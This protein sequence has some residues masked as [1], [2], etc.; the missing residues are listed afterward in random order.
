MASQI[1]PDPAAARHAS[2]EAPTIPGIA[3]AVT[4]KDEELF[5]LADR[6][7]RVPLEGAHGLGLF[8]HDCRYLSGYELTFAG[9]R[10]TALVGSD[11]RGYA[12]NYQLAN[13]ELRL[14]DGGVVR[15]L[16]VGVEWRRALVGA[17]RRLEE[18]LIFSNFG[19]EAVDLPIELAF[20][21]RF[22]DVFLVR[23][24]VSE[25][26][27][28]IR[29]PRWKGCELIFGYDGRDGLR[30]GLTVAFS[31]NP[32]LRS[33][34]SAAFTAELEPGTPWELIVSL[35]VT[36]GD[37]P[38][39]MLPELDPV[40]LQRVEQRV[41]RSMEAWLGAMPEIRSDS[42]LLGRV[43]HRS[44]ADVR[45]LRSRV[46]NHE[47]V[48]AGLPW[49]ATLFGRDSLITAMELLA[50]DP[51]L[52]EQ[53]L[54]LLARFQ[55]TEVDPWRDEQPGKIL[56]ELR[57]GELARLGE[58]PHT[59][60][61]GTVDATPLFLVLLARHAR[62]TGSL[63]LFHELRDAA[64]RA[65]D[66]VDGQ[67]HTD[68]QGFVEYRRLSPRGL[69]NQ[70]W[71]DSGDAIVTE[72][73]RLAAPPISLVEVQAYTYAAKLELAEVFERAGD[74]AR[75]A[76]LRA[77]ANALRLRFEQCYWL[78][79]LGSYALALEAGGRPARVI[80]SN[81]GHT[82]WCGIASPERGRRVASRLM[83]EDMFN[84][85][86]I[87]TLS[88]KERRYNPVGYHLGSVW[89]HDNA[90][91]AAGMR[92]YGCDSEA[93]AVFTGLA[94][95]AMH[96]DDY[97]LPELFA[98][99]SRAAFEIPVKYPVACHPQAWAA[100]SMPFLLAV[101]LGLVS[102]GFQ[103]ELRMVRPMLPPFVHEL[104]IHRLPVSGGS[105]SLR[106][107]RRKDGTAEVGL[108]ERAADVQVRVDDAAGMRTITG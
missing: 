74:S 107:M 56:H 25:P 98:G 101:V 93:L 13:P 43:L 91:A 6:H 41:E 60:Y 76:L 48:C 4:I 27:G 39:T 40:E 3:S 18:R 105:V 73:G 47:Y 94:H 33:A 85:W 108:I 104:E 23:N 26:G 12:A 80:A 61:Y 11:A 42:L 2:L 57:V 68:Q 69:G 44:F 83:A 31:R 32:E 79:E 106:F 81:A 64:E 63:E 77:Q 87:R 5:F 9:V 84:G 21:A 58:I 51:S 82:L 10:P 15:E 89:P 102:D 50:Y 24:V 75:G 90:I 95:A 88:A 22:E 1:Q 53:T 97:R 66:W 78:E 34:E 62:A 86:G 35:T 8:F 59:P 67:S 37:E 71:K 54:R 16:Q 14:A 20:R 7:G 96:F 46:G 30:R 28:K 45:L 65:L 92:C 72:T 52:A 29:A 17:E 103:R 55:G 100:A 36:E 99:F 38:D 49:Y 19:H 70:G